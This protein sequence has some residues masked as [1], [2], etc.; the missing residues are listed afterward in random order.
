MVLRQFTAA[1]VV[2]IAMIGSPSLAI[3]WSVMLT[4]GQAAALPEAARAPYQEAVRLNDRVALDSVVTELAKAASLA[5]DHIDLQFLLLG[6]AR[7]RAMNYYGTASYTV[8]NNALPMAFNS[9]PNMVAE[10]YLDIADTAIRRL[11]GNSSLNAEQRRRLEAQGKAIAELR[12]GLEARDQ[13]RAKVGFPLI[14]MIRADRLEY[15]DSKTEKDDPLDPFAAYA[16][17]VNKSPD[18]PDATTETGTIDPFALLPGEVVSNFLPPSPAPVNNFGPEFGN[19][20]QQLDEFGNPITA[21]QNVG[22]ALA[23]PGVP[24][25]GPEDGG[26]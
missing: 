17:G 12:S 22:G 8:D 11:S 16:K 1:A 3:D 18:S 21:P 26:K 24:A 20:P 5:E 23:D 10:P 14:E 19:Q 15:L 4:D 9:P 13:A 7:D 2:A 6:R 25:F